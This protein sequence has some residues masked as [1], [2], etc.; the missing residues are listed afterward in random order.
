MQFLEDFLIHSCLFKGLGSVYY[1]HFVTE[2]RLHDWLND[3]GEEGLDVSKDSMVRIEQSH[4]KSVRRFEC[5]E[6]FKQ[7]LNTRLGWL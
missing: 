4:D 6:Q 5:F 1:E 3:L 7:R 2:L